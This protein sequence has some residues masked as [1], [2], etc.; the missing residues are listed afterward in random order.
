M[1]YILCFLFQKITIKYQSTIL[2][3]YFNFLA[4]LNLYYYYHSHVLKD[5]SIPISD[6]YITH[7][8]TV[9]TEKRIAT[10]QSVM[11]VGLEVC[12]NGRYCKH[13]ECNAKIYIA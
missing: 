10:V 7:I 5:A 9:H 3:N 4:Y 2:P 8:F 13:L 11:A 1:F 12:P 6:L